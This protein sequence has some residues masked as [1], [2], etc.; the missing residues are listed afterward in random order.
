M[1]KNLKSM[2]GYGK[3]EAVIADLKFTVEVRSLNSKQLDLN[4]RI[5]YF[6]RDK[7]MQYRSMAAESVVRG[8]VDI[9]IHA[10]NMK[11]TA[12]PAMNVTLM[13]QYAEILKSFTTENDIP[14]SD[15]LSAI[16]R[17]PEVM[18]AEETELEE[19]ALNQVTILLQEALKNLDQYRRAEGN[20]LWND[21][22]LRM[23]G[24]L[25]GRIALEQPL[26]NRDANVRQR[27]K[28]SLEELVPIDKIDPNRFEQEIIYYLE[29]LDISEEYARLLANCQHF[30]EELMGEG[31]GKKLG[32]IAQ[33]MGRE[34]NTIGSKANDS[35]I[36]R[37]VVMMKDELEKIK[38]QI[39]NVL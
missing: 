24:I 31:Q 36:Q 37:I 13:K 10:E 33:E 2:T 21:L 9:F 11:Q 25:E 26:K 30:E 14:Q 27:L 20:T 5:P 3:A 12:G 6:L 7:E 34:I 17:M 1:N 39:N 23:D 15:L 18:K 8:K 22:K 35:D 28:S 4:A 19:G 32:F 16:L 38:E 29:R